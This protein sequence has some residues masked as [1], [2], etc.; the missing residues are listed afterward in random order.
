MDQLVILTLK[1][2]GDFVAS[3]PCTC[4]NKI[5][6]VKAV[7]SKWLTYSDLKVFHAS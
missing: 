1:G 6:L 7:K 5:I 2:V 4:T 3:H